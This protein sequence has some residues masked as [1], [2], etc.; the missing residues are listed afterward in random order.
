M[1]QWLEAG[2]FK[3]DLPISQQPSGPFHQLSLYFPDMT[4]AFTV[5]QTSNA[6]AE[7]ETRARAQAEEEERRRRQIQLQREEEER[8]R[9]AAEAAAA[10]R[11]EAEAAAEAE[12]E[13]FAAERMVAETNRKLAEGSNGSSRQ[14]AQEQ[15]ESSHQL[16][17]LLGLG[18]S[19]SLSIDA[20]DQ[21]LLN[22]HAES[23]SSREAVQQHEK[24]AQKP[25]RVQHRVAPLEPEV[26]EV[27][28]P[29][30]PSAPAWGGAATSK[31][32][33]RKS[34][35]EI[36]Q[37]EARAAE[38]L[39]MQRGNQP[40]PNQRSGWANVAASGTTAAWSGAPKPAATAVVGVNTVAATGVA[41]LATANP[42]LAPTAARPRQ[43]GPNHAATRPTGA[44]PVQQRSNDPANVDEFGASMNPTL[45]RW[46]KDQM[47]KLN[48]SDD[49][50]LV[51][52]VI[53][54]D[55]LE[56]VCIFLSSLI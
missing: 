7:D 33:P 10:A 29:A 8:H 56:Y 35:S 31:A 52:C 34:M 47:I 4:A 21:P 12:R 38:R 30:K 53:D 2:Y 44:V 36:Q 9:R 26:A 11:A 24:P 40:G 13:R 19:S 17:M 32:I 3:G 6:A 41:R 55:H 18:S 43:P 27:Q 22:E 54:D 20:G 28:V 48:G 16:K 39:A 42:G 37:E 5:S 23:R 49:L 25:A 15:N 1:R 45:E 50:T 46:C 14:E 51:S